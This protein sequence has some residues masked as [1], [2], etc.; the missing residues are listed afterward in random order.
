MNL[1]YGHITSQ[2]SHHLMH[3]VYRLYVHLAHPETDFHFAD[4]QKKH[5]DHL[6]PVDHPVGN[7]F[8]HP[9]APPGLFLKIIQVL[10]LGKCYLHVTKHM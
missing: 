6:C 4:Q 1:A 3:Q 7:L 8:V 10:K 5:L 9:L 2:T